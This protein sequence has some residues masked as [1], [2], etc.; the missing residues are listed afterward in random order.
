MDE[1]TKRPLFANWTAAPAHQP[2][3]TALD[4]PDGKYRIEISQ[5]RYPALKEVAPGVKCDYYHI[6]ETDDI[7]GFIQQASLLLAHNAGP[8]DMLAIDIANLLNE[9]QADADGI[10]GQVDQAP[11]VRTILVKYAGKQLAITVSEA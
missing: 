5:G 6:D 10:I 11:D 1:I 4:S 8:A 2:G 7:D 3:M 9:K